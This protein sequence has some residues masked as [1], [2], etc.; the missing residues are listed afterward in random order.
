MGVSR[1]MSVQCTSPIGNLTI[2]AREETVIAVRWGYCA[3]A[4]TSPVL[5]EA[6]GQM[7]AYFDGRLREFALPLNPAGGEFQQRVFARMRAIPYGQTRTYGELAEALGSFGQPVGQACGANP[8]PVIIPC[9]RVLGANDLGGY[10]GQ[11]GIETKTVLL[12]L[13]NAFPYLI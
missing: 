2:Q 5:R 1:L 7:Q 3:P 11:G 13:E 4:A 6:K 9:H 10:S 8:I 12:K